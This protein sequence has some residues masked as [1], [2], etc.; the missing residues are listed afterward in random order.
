MNICANCQHCHNEEDGPRTHVWY[1]W[2]CHAVERE[3]GQDCVN[4]Q[5]G[6][7]GMNDLGRGYVDSQQYEYCRDVNKGGEC[8]HYLQKFGSLV[9]WDEELRKFK[10][11]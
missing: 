6:W 11:N 5:A 4:G 9:D 2:F 1:N 10:S 3:I 8:P 7:V